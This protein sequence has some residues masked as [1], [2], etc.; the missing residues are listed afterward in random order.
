MPPTNAIIE[1]NG[2]RFACEHNWGRL[3][4]DYAWGIT[5][6][7]AEDSRGNIYIAHTV[8]ESSACR[9]TVVVFDAQGRFVR[10]WG[11]AFQGSAHGLEIAEEHGSEYVYLTDLERGLFKLTLEGEVVWRFEKPALY[12]KIFG[13]NW[14]PSNVAMAPATDLY[15]VD[16][17]GTG[18]IIRIDRKSGREIDCFG[19]PG[20]MCHNLVHPHGLIVDTRQGEPLLLVAD[21]VDNRFHYLTLDGQHVRFEHEDDGILVAPRHFALRGELLLMPDLGGRISLFDG[22]NTHL[23][24]LGDAGSSFEDLVALHD[25]PQETF[26]HGTFYLPHDAIF[27]RAGNIFVV[28][29][30]TTGRVTKLTRL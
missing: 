12:R 20:K 13:L 5:H 25:A 6:G 1:A 2:L 19:G 17:Y 29:W 14:R 28:E 10:S 24:C 22:D 4:A 27:D 18:F 15:L 8:H 7:V 9:D 23:G 16:G 21:N 26:Q 11:E 30:I 3:P